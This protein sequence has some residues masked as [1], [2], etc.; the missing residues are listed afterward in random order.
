M[1][2]LV[3][4]LYLMALIIWVGEVIFF[5][6]VGAPRLFA[7][8]PSPEA[9]KAVGAI[10]PAYYGIGYGCGVVL[11]VGALVLGGG[12]AARG[13][14]M[15]NALLAAVMLAVTLYAGTVVQPQ[16][17]TLRP[18]F[19]DATAPAAVKDEFSRLHRLAVT[20]N[21]VVLVCGLAVSV[22]TASSIKP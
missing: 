10:F 1:L 9:G 5:S 14:W 20:L 7:T 12:A 3:K 17:T 8:F 4:W 16:L 21:G 6:F 22:I 18:Q 11:L 19:H 2:A 15:T 13:W